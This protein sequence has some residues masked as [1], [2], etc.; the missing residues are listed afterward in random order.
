M[1][2]EFN[3]TS[4][5]HRQALLKDEEAWTSLDNAAQ[6][7]IISMLPP[8]RL[9]DLVTTIDG[10]Q[11]LNQAVL[12]TN[13]SWN[14]FIGCV[15]DDI[16]LGRNKPGW[17]QDANT[18]YLERQVGN[19]DT[20]KEK[21]YEEFWGVKQ[22]LA[23]GVIAG[24]SASLKWDDLVERGCFKAGD[25]FQYSRRLNGVLVQKDVEVMYSAT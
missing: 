3:I 17:L 21:E 16:S 13:S 11:Q 10:K 14:Y 19:Y 7:K 23:A 5:T 18:A 15:R 1:E 6:E 12:M 2:T 24:S 9:A 20:W 4:L 8:S 22:K 25:V